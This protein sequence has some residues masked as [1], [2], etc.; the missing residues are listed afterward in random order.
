MIRF[1]KGEWKG[2]PIALNDTPEVLNFFKKVW[3]DN[4]GARVAHETLSNKEFWGI[5]LTTICGLEDKV[6]RHLQK[7]KVATLTE[8]I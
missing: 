1:Y 2:E 5:D 3:S 4:D 8:Q 6:K 7:M